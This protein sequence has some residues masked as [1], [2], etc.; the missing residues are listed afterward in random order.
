MQQRLKQIHI[1]LNAKEKEMESVNYFKIKSNIKSHLS[2][3]KLFNAFIRGI[4]IRIVN[5]FNVWE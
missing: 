4:S 2:G 3:R 1:D 5:V